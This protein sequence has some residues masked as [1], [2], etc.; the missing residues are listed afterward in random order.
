MSERSELDRLKEKALSQR[1]RWLI[2]AE[3]FIIFGLL[4]WASLEYENN[5]YLQSWLATYVGP[6]GFLLNGTL[7]G[8]YA[9]GLVGYVVALFASRK[10]EEERILE[11]VTGKRSV[12]E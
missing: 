10:S 8:L 4:V 3:S 12:R 2:W 5:G 7:A 9:G 6:F 1:T 11:S